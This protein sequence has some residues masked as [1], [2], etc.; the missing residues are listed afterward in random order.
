M[1]ANLLYRDLLGRDAVVALPE[2]EALLGRAAGAVVRSDDHTVS[3]QHA[4]I[5]YN[6]G[7]WF[8]EDLSTPNGTFV[9]D[10]RVLQRQILM[11]GDLIRC[12]S[13]QVRYVEVAHPPIDPSLAPPQV[14]TYRLLRLIGSGAE[15]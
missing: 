10:Q 2:G 15:C 9:N 1:P 5:T 3:R 6:A 7:A 4:S 11:N 13:L 12:G 14:G 8:V